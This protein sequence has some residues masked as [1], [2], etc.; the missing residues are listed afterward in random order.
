MMTDDSS[1]EAIL[2]AFKLNEY[3]VPVH[4]EPGQFNTY[5]ELESAIVETVANTITSNVEFLDEGDT[6]YVTMKVDFN[7]DGVQDVFEA[8]ESTMI[9]VETV[10][11]LGNLNE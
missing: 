7:R 6:P 2:D 8:G 11:Q 5:D 4:I 1:T 9:D 3:R 10:T